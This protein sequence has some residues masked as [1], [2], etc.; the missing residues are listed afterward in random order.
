MF[1]KRK[2]K[3]TSDE[4]SIILLLKNNNIDALVECGDTLDSKSMGYFIGAIASGEV[5]GLILQEMSDA[6]KSQGREDELAD[7]YNYIKLYIQQNS[8]TTT[9]DDE[10]I[11]S[12]INA[13]RRQLTMYQ[14]QG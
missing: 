12:P 7:V 10:P 8:K 2:Q 9:S 14:P 4:C 1:N 6:L 3:T 5:L 11:V 13:I